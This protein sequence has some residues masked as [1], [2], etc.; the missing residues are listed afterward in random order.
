MTAPAV[1]TWLLTFWILGVP[2]EGGQYVSEWRCQRG[3]QQQIHYWRMMYS[4]N[5]KWRCELKM[6]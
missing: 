5:I 6:P 1:P 3:A 2:Y 4:A